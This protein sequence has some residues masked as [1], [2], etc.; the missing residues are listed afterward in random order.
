[1]TVLMTSKST[2][3]IPYR[4]WQRPAAVVG[5]SFALMDRRRLLE[6][7]LEEIWT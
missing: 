7:T 2:D 5:D 1:M 4:V 3:R 6:E